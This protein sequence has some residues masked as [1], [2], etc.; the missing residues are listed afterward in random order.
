MIV[1]RWLFWG[2]I[3]AGMACAVAHAIGRFDLTPVF[4]ASFT[5]LMGLVFVHG[6]FIN[7]TRIGEAWVIGIGWVTPR[8]NPLAYWAVLSIPALVGV[9]IFL[10]G[11]WWWIRIFGV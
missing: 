9:A 2:C 7:A 6:C 4:G 5:S 1:W 8:S 3:V 11:I 10:V